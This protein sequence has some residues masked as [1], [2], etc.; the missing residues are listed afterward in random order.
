MMLEDLSSVF[1][2]VIDSKKLPV[3]SQVQMQKGWESLS[4]L[5]I[6]LKEHFGITNFQKAAETTRKLKIENSTV[7]LLK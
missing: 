5:D 1:Y 6:L 3:E 7:S 4:K 2:D